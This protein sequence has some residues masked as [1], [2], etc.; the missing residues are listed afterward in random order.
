MKK[1]K[2][3]HES[4]RIQ[5]ENSIQFH[6][7]Y[8]FL[9]TDIQFLKGVGP[10]RAI[11]L[12]SKKIFTFYDFLNFLPSNYIDFR[13]ICKVKNA[14]SSE[15]VN[16]ILK[17]KEL[18]EISFSK[19]KIAQAVFYDETGEIIVKWFNYNLNYLRSFLK[20]NRE[21]FISGKLNV[22]A[23][24]KEMIH[25]I[26][27]ESQNFKREIVPV[28]N[29]IK[30]FPQKAI[31]NS[32]KFL[33]E[34]I[35]K[36]IDYLPETIVEKENYPKIFQ[37]YENLHFPDN[38]EN[39]KELREFSSI[40]HKR[41]I[42]DEFFFV[43]LAVSK[44]KKKKAILKT[45]PIIYKGNLVK[46][47][48]DSLPFELTSSQKKV[49]REIYS[50]L[51]SGKVMNR[52]IQGDVGSG[53]TLVAFISALMIIENNYQ[54]AFMAPTEILA[55]QHYN[56]FK[57]LSK[58][59]DISF[60]ILTGSTPKK[61]KELIIEDLK[62]GKIDFII[63][64]H[65]LIEENIKFKNLRLNIIDEQ[66][67]FGVRQRLS[68]KQKGSYVHTLI[69]TAT[70]IPRTLTLTIYGDLDVSIIDKMPPGRKPI[71]T[72]WFYERQY[73][74]Y[75]PLIKEELK[76]GRQAYFV[77]PLIEES[78]K[79]EL[80]DVIKMKEK[81][82]KELFPEFKVGLMHG[83]MKSTEKENIMNKFKN[84]EIDI[85]ATT[86]VVEVG[87][88]VPNATVMVIEN[89]ERFGLAQ[90]HQLRGRIGRGKAQS[91][92]FLISSNKISDIAKRRLKI[93]CETN[94][95]FKIAEEDLKI[96]GPGEILGTRQS[97]MP[98]FKFADLI[99]D[100]KI[101]LK[102]KEYANIIVDYDFT[103][104]KFPLLKRMYED[105][106]EEKSKLAEAG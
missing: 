63:G 73:K 31:R 26:I 94:D 42:F 71:K 52:L 45:E 29:E 30:N 62:N 79:L 23:F 90:L 51:K 81:L 96:R 24:Y 39:I 2:S 4:S 18:Q 83:R 35:D 74:K 84:G 88:D 19:R 20:K 12:K 65:T 104:E 8:S 1:E 16:L 100:F 102:A 76:K 59:L 58:N 93:M 27:Q 72:Y 54:V 21:Y 103:L 66:H 22:Y 91:Y 77:Y 43:M 57:N 55:Q 85:L 50:D 80:K 5:F 6:K 64:T 61:T 95:G 56:N 82:E 68:L 17:F 46:K 49:L 98:E 10:K 106:F 9:K 92:C 53:K 7:N 44:E 14:K 78:E 69:M 86:T 89:A 48:I 105:F 40:Y 28:Y 25:P 41:L 34:N 67:K 60:A 70:P 99:R 15:N 3:L 13:K 97:G 38:N 47:F 36:K 87:V 32:M 37:C 75:I 11:Y 101:L 33:I